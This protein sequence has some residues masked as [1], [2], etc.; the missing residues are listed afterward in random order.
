MFWPW[1]N[2]EAWAE[3]LRSQGVNPE[4]GIPFEPPP[5]V[6][7]LCKAD[8]GIET[9]HIQV[10]PPPGLPYGR[11]FHIDCLVNHMCANIDNPK[12]E[13]SNFALRKNL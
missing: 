2:P 12:D 7:E 3:Y 6:C 1:T 5:L 8:I 11:K 13:I 9:I 4:T 10:D